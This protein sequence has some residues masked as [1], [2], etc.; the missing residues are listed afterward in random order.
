MWGQRC[1]RQRCLGPHR[2]RFVVPRSNR[3]RW[4]EQARHRHLHRRPKKRTAQRP[5]N[6]GIYERWRPFR[7]CPPEQGRSGPRLASCCVRACSEN[8][9][10]TC[11]VDRPAARL[12]HGLRENPPRIRRDAP[13]IGCLALD[14][15]EQP[16]LREVLVVRTVRRPHGVER[17]VGVVAFDEDVLRAGRRRRVRACLAP[18]GGG[19]ETSTPSTGAYHWRTVGC[20]WPH[21]NGGNSSITRAVFGE[22]IA[23][24]AA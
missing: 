17:H 11:L 18:S 22:R 8:S 5:T 21:A 2:A 19:P 4:A 7:G 16:D 15:R 20:D 9:P 3:R 24:E 6:V 12:R 23:R 1:M 10:P 14:D 13:A